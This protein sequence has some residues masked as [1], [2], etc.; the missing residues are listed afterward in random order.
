MPKYTGGVDGDEDDAPESGGGKNR[1]KPGSLGQF[2]GTDALRQE[3]KV[4]R[5]VAVKLGLTDD[6]STKLH[7]AVSGQGLDYKGVL[8]AAIGLYPAKAKAKGIKDQ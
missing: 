3:N 5:D 4:V 1:R 7:Q 2:K 6:E 8:K